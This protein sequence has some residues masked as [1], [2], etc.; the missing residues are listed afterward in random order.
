MDTMNFD[1]LTLI[2]IPV[3][4]NKEKFFLREATEDAARQYRNASVAAARMEDGKVVGVSG[5]GD[6]QSL[7]IS[8]CLFTADT[9]KNIPLSVVRGWPS[10]IVRPLFDKAKEISQLDEKDTAATLEEKITKLQEQLSSIKATNGED[11]AKN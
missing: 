3:S 11:Q 9:G 10:R 6:I 1:D 8:L 7:L 4:I 5:V 2:E